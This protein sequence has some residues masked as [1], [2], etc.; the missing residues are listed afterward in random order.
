MLHPELDQFVELAGRH[1]FAVAL[2]S[3]LVRMPEPGWFLRP[4]LYMVSISMSG[5]SDETYA[6][7]HRGGS[8]SR[9]TANVK[10][11]A[12]SIGTTG[13][14]TKLE[15]RFHV[16]RYNANELP[17]ARAFCRDW[18]IRFQPYYGSFG[19]V[20]GFRTFFDTGT[21]E[22][23][24]RFRDYVREH[25]FI[26]RVARNSLAGRSIQ[27]CPQEQ[28]LTI[29]WDGSVLTCCALWE[30]PGGRPRIWEADL[31]KYAAQRTQNEVCHQCMSKGWAADINTFVGPEEA[32]GVHETSGSERQNKPLESDEDVD[33]AG[34]G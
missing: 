27:V 32:L 33:S 23:A 3:N 2:S 20:E 22:Q 18:G 31:A 12:E 16:Y 4:N 28:V 21:S 13:L 15:L 10:R 6:I 25:V 34:H 26:E 29:D 9:V 1:D 14:P 24:Q 17:E 11:L 8:F 7:N 19:S 30:E 5:F